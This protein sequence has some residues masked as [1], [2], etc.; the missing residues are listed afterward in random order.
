MGAVD[1][2]VWIKASPEQVWRVYVDPSRIPEWQTG[3]PVIEELHGSADQPGSSYVS[4]RRPGA[5]RTTVTKAD[6]PS[7][8]ITATEAYFGFRLDVRSSLT[9]QSGGT[10]LELHVETH[11][12]EGW[13]CSE[14]GR[15]GDPQ[16]SGGARRNSGASRHLSRAT[17]RPRPRRKQG[18]PSVVLIP[19]AASSV[20]KVPS[21]LK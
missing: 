7:L 21:A 10:L 20:L 5:A 9:T 13:V 3:S 4:R 15:G 16:P 2:S 14:A 19:A 18:Q 6:K 11:W 12:P 1:Y 8:L 17:S